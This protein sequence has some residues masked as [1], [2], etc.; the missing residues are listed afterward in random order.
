MKS[1][2]LGQIY[3]GPEITDN[4]ILKQLPDDLRQVLTWRNGFIQ[5]GGGFHFRGACHSPDWHSLREVWQGP[6]ALHRLYPSVL[7]SDIPFGQDCVGDQY[8]LRGGKVIRL[9]SESGDIESLGVGL[10]EFL[11]NAKQDPVEYLSLGPLLQFQE[12]GHRL[13]PGQL[14]NVYPP[15]IFKESE[16]G[17]SLKAVPVKERL[18]F[19]AHLAASIRTGE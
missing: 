2:D 5:C 6:T 19:L 12:E 9:T 10:P 18:S 15:Y 8:L 11:Q 14:I 7:P 17:V 16:K 3:T 13:E 4:E 1:Y